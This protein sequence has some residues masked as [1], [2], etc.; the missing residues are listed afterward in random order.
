MSK[1]IKKF[2]CAIDGGAS[3]GKTTMAKLVGKKYNFSVLYSGLLFRYAAKMVME[4]KPKNKVKFLKKKFSNINY[5]KVKKI[6]LHTPKISSY[7]AVIAK[8]IKIRKI[9]K[10]FQKKYVQKKRRVVLE[11]RDMSQIF[12][13]ADV[14]FFVVCRPL[15][16]AAKRRWLQIRKKKQK[17]SLKEVKKD[18]IKRDYLDK[19]RRHSPLVKA[20]D[21]WYINTAKLNIKGVIS[22]A[23]LIIDRRIKSKYGS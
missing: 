13:N 7:S 20:S 21:S 6:N 2:I 1:K 3:S 15:K 11:G 22:K 5:E 12:P 19:H 23:S 14:K 10:S 4:K 8:E 17:T 18:L 9:I 16:I